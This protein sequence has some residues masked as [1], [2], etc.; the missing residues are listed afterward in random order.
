M[1][2][3]KMNNLVRE[4]TV[5]DLG[6][7]SFPGAHWCEDS[8]LNRAGLQLCDL[9]WKTSGRQMK[10]SI[11]VDCSL[12]HVVSSWSLNMLANNISNWRAIQ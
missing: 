2:L 3:H 6:L 11:S 8:D 5:F 9:K 10:D 7:T 12:K 4:R 1:T